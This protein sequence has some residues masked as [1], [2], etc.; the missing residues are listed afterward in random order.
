MGAGVVG[1]A[2]AWYLA[3]AGHDVAVVDR[4]PGAGRETSFANG[5]Q[6]S[7]CHAEPWANPSTPLK[8]LRWMGR[9]DAP[10]VLRWRRW[11]PALWAWSARFLLNCTA[12]RTRLN[13]E[14][15]LRVAV[16]SR[17]CLQALRRETGIE[18]DQ[19]ALGILHVYRDARE[20]GHAQKASELMARLG[21]P[22][23]VKT[24]DEAVAIEPALS[25]VRSQLAGAIYTPDD[26]SGDAHIFTRS[27]AALCAR[28]GVKFH[29]GTS[30]IGLEWDAGRL[31]S[32]ATTGGRLR[33][34][35]FVLALGSW[36]P[37]LARQVGLQLPVY[38]GKGYSATL[39]VTDESRAPN[40]SITDDEHKMVYSRLGGRLRCAGTA[41]L[42]GWN[43]DMTPARAR[44]LVAHAE[45][46][47]PGAGDFAAA[48]LWAGLRPVTPDSVPLLGATP[49]DNLYLNT[50]HG[51]LGWTMSCGSGRVLADIISGRPPDIDM[52]GLGLERFCG[53]SSLRGLIAQRQ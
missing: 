49:V 23:V 32:I 17:A 2:T 38:P 40:V 29:Y 46:L 27:L 4:Q 51:T 25:A 5:G 16:Y 44:A 33:A 30:I 11:D 24:A 50:G 26:E 43:P 47:F 28:A 8:A 41:E 36:S 39:P 3:K 22:R 10:L 34:D 6:V 37:I 31:T 14:R 9:E 18:Y 21:L 1:V 48:E 53:L 35:A 15:I 13:T 7:P 45:G 19:K 52:S 12:A 42:A 20:F